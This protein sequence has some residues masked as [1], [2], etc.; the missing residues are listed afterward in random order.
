MSVT[1]F[2]G[3]YGYAAVL[4]GA[5]LQAETIVLVA[6]FAAHE[7][8][9]SPALVVLLAFIGGAAGD[10]AFFWIGRRWGGPLQRRVPRLNARLLQVAALLLRWDAVLVFG[11][12][13]V[14]GLRIAGPIAMGT[15]GVDALRFAVFNVLGAAVWTA[16]FFALG[17]LLGQEI[18]TLLGDMDG[19][20]NAI[21][22]SLLAAVALFLVMRRLRQAWRARRRARSLPEA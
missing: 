11:V 21:L 15:L 14:Y 16:A 22:W 10:Q 20:E 4:A 17:Y 3:T 18:G 9:L 1:E 7:G 6:G 13:F 5:L 2:I 19:Y 8:Y 12:R